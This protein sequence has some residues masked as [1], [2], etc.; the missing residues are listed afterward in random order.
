[1]EGEREAYLFDGFEVMRLSSEVF[2]AF[3]VSIL[4]GKAVEN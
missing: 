4:E 2:F 1:M 3:S